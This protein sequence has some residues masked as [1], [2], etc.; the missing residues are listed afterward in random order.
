MKAQLCG[1]L[2]A[3]CNVIIFLDILWYILINEANYLITEKMQKHVKLSY[4]DD[5]TKHGHKAKTSLGLRKRVWL[6][7]WNLQNQSDKILKLQKAQLQGYSVEFPV[8]S[9]SLKTAL[10][11]SFTVTVLFTRMYS[12]HHSTS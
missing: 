7:G 4:D 10:Y 5:K 1:T 9:Q 6:L 11:S 12:I 8:T 3:S 2:C